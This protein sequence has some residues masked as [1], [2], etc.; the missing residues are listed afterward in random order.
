MKLTVGERLPGTGPPHQP[1]GYLVTGV[2]AETPWYGLYAG[3]KIFY[4]FDFTS[5]R[6][7]ETDDKE[8][9]DVYLRTIHYPVL[10]D[11]GYVSRR[12]TLARAEARRV[13]ANRGSNLWP[14]PIDVLDLHNTR[15]PFSFRGKDELEPVLVF[16]RPQGQ[17]LFD[18]QNNVLPLSS[19]LGVLA[20]LLEFVRLAHEEGLLLNG[21]SPA[22]VIVD[23]ADRVHY[24]GTDMVLD[25]RDNSDKVGVRRS[26][27]DRP[28]FTPEEW[29]RYFPAQRFARGYAPPES[30]QGSVPDRRADLYAWAS[31]AYFLVTGDKPEQTAQEQ[32]QWWTRFHDAHFD[33]LERALRAV[34]PAH[35]LR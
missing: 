9:L 27:L 16:A 6:P 29:P 20:E 4:N 10:D 3:K 25:V 22:T 26:A 30:L 31:I 2:V 17:N 11:A 12:R 32:E 18:W 24:V 15:D 1:G 13:L 14:E 34:P 5:K 28:A 33:K 7:R 35:V 23:Q 8:W 21:L 19:I